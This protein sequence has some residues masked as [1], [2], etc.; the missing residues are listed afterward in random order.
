[1]A[2]HPASLAVVET[3]EAPWLV[4]AVLEVAAALQPRLETALLNPRL[5]ASPGVVA[6]F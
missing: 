6:I 2:N 1:M 4:L 3:E 5:M